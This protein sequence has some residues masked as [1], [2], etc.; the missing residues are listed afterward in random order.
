MRSIGIK[1][2]LQG[3]GSSAA[4]GHDT[5]ERCLGTRTSIGKF[6]AAARFEAQVDTGRDTSNRDETSKGVG[7]GLN[8]MR[9]NGSKE[10]L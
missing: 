5:V 8:S 7:D 1:E 2:K 6:T 9:S 4:S 10:M 3:S